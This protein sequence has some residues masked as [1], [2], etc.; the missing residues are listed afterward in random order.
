M[1][2]YQLQ[3]L[4]PMYMV[5]GALGTQIFGLKNSLLFYRSTVELRSQRSC[6]HIQWF[7]WLKLAIH[8]GYVTLDWYHMHWNSQ[9]CLKVMNT[10]T[11]MSCIKTVCAHCIYSQ[12]RNYNFIIWYS[13]GG[14]WLVRNHN[15]T[16]SIPSLILICNTEHNRSDLSNLICNTEQNRSD[17]S[18]NCITICNME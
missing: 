1:K 13:G 15:Y 3:T 2:Y 8:N 4:K 5:S 6:D 10:R 14:F 16:E 18:K 17:L 7:Q 9:K 12:F 11:A